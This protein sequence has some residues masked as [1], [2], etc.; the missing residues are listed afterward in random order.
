VYLANTTYSFRV[1]AKSVNNY[2]AYSNTA[3]ATLTFPAPSNLSVTSVTATSANLQWTDNST[4]ENGFLIERSTDGVTFSVV[5][6]VGANVTARSVAGVYLA[7]T[8]YSF[9]VRAKSTYNVS[10]Y[11]NV[12][13]GLFLVRDASMVMVP[14]SAFQMGST[15]GYS[16]ET[17]VHSVTLATFYV[18]KTEITYEK[19]TDVRNW[20]LTHGYTDLASGQ[21]GFN[22]S[23]TNNPATMVNWYDILKWCNARSEKD[24]L[25]PVYYT[26]NTLSIVYRTGQL[27]LASD[28]VKW[29]ANGYRLPTEAEWEFAARGGTKSKGYTYSGSNNLDSVGWYNGNSGVSTHT[30]GTK[31]ANELGLYDMTGNVFEWC[32]DWYATYSALSQTNPR[33]PTSGTS[34]VLRGGSFFVTE[35][36]CPVVFRNSNSPE[37]RSGTNGFRTVQ[38]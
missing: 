17:P 38:N 3:S 14:G 15:V 30:V 23:G 21:N 20:G 6:S 18:D 36:Y 10:P 33:G 34:R 1:R 27:D 35:L 7:N 31:G 13:S 8:T 25:T 24:G 19:W 5:D 29:T 37:G 12:S 4:F 32:W 2:S 9:R 11:S 28:A 26:S 22:P 16:D